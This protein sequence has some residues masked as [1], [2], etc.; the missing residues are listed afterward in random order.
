MAKRYLMYVAGRNLGVM[1]RAL[2]GVG[3]PKSL[4]TEGE[5]SPGAVLGWFQLL[6]EC[7][8]RR[9]TESAA[10]LTGNSDLFA[11]GR[12]DKAA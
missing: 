3:T 6:G 10:H 11:P 9:W 12:V 4:Q 1:M 5:A 8:R 2:F 7:L